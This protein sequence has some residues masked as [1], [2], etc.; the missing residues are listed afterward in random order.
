MVIAV[1]A[2]VLAAIPVRR[3]IAVCAMMTIVI[4]LFAIV[5]A[6]LAVAVTVIVIA[7]VY[8]QL[9]ADIALPVTIVGQRRSA[10]K[11]QQ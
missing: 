5:I 9:P 11:Y 3:P 10:A 7:Q 4:M 1:M 8:K 6:M 2:E